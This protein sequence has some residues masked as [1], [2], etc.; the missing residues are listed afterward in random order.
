MTR[1]HR[2][3]RLEKAA[4]TVRDTHE[5]QEQRDTD[6]DSELQAAWTIMSQTM[7]EEHARMVVDAYGAGLQD[8]RHPDWGSPAGS[9]LR[10]CLDAL[11]RRPYGP[12]TQIEPEVA[13]AMPP[14]M[15]DVYLAHRDALPLHQ[16]E[17]CG[18]R[19]PHK[20]FTECPL[21]GGRVGWNA[22][23]HQHKDDPRT[24]R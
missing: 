13:L 4:V 8:V 6:H 16:C 12:Y 9:L 17:E 11:N 1:L 24:E 5:A 22:Y 15:A 20:Y 18:Y 14:V 2:L 3:E 10:R 7:S 19:V 21:C 23:W